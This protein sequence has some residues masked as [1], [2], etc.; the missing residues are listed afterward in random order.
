MQEGNMYKN[1]LA[2]LD[3]SE[4]SEC[5]LKHVTAIAKGC[6]V[7]GVVL[8]HIIEPLNKYMTYGGIGQEALGEIRKES[9]TKAKR[10]M[11]KAADKLKKNGINAKT[12]I[13]EGMPSDEIL[14]YT[15]KNQVD[16]IIMSTHGS[17]GLTRWAFGSV[18]DKVIRHSPVPVLVIAP[19]GCR[20]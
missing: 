8:L 12:V 14:N 15:E 5:S 3:G 18:A 16:L 13:I 6:A 7:A 20:K 4:L 17:S 9:R 10:Y 11:A 19:P 1:I 2:P